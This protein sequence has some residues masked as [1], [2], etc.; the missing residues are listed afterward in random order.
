MAQYLN[1][2]NNQKRSLNSATKCVQIRKTMQSNVKNAFAMAAY[3]K[4][5]GFVISG[6]ETISGTQKGILIDATG[7]CVKV[8]I[9]NL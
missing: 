9:G 8:T 6:R 3:L 1:E 7:S 5:K 2:I 4:T